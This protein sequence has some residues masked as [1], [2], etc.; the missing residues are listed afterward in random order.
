MG[1]GLTFCTA[2]MWVLEYFKQCNFI[3]YPSNST[4]VLH[5]KIT[6]CVIL[7]ICEKYKIIFC[8]CDRKLSLRGIL[9]TENCRKV[10]WRQKIVAE[11]SLGH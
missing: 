7:Q 2:S 9:A 11:K 5:Q 3:K 8:R 1:L 4:F 10:N 6:V